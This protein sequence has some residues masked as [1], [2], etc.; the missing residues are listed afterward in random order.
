MNCCWR[1][2]RYVWQFIYSPLNGELK[3]ALAA[4]GLESFQHNWIG[5]QNTALFAVAC[6]DA[7][8]RVVVGTL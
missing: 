6:H 8:A 2:G 5:I 7:G 1:I 4:L 3:P